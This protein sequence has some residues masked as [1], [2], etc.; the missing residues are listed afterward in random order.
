M[1]SPH[2]DFTSSVGLAQQF[3][4]RLAEVD[5]FLTH[6]LILPN[7]SLPLFHLFAHLKWP[8][9]HSQHKK[10]GNPVKIWYRNLY[11]HQNDNNLVLAS[12][13]SSRVVFAIQNDHGEP[14]CVTV[15]VIDA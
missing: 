5:H 9:M 11:E 13:I 6:S 12:N 7:N 10:Y 1:A 3:G 2:F 15:P 14:T 8:M 4:E